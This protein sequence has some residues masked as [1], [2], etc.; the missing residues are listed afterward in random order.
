MNQGGAVTSTTSGVGSEGRRELYYR[1]ARPAVVEADWHTV[2]R[3][4]GARR[5]WT[6]PPS[7]DVLA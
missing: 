5:A 4:R 7:D 2:T 3:W 1:R 6:V